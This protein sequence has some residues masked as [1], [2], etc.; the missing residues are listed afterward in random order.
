MTRV[1]PVGD[2][3]L[4]KPD[5]APAQAGGI[6]LP[7]VTTH[8]DTATIVRLSYTSTDAGFMV[9]TKVLYDRGAAR[10]AGVDNPDLQ[11]IEYKDIRGVLMDAPLRLGDGKDDGN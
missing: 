6:Y 3:I 2:W 7:S 1:I 5:G 10:G 8:G 9:G 4:I 11:L